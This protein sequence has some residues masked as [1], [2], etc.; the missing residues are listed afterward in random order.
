MRSASVSLAGTALRGQERTREEGGFEEHMTHGLHFSLLPFFP[1]QGTEAYERHPRSPAGG[2]HLCS[3]LQGC[4]GG[5]PVASSDL[6]GFCVEFHMPC[7]CPAPHIARR[8]EGGSHSERQTSRM[9]SMEP[10]CRAGAVQI[11]LSLLSL[12]PCSSLGPLHGSFFSSKLSAQEPPL[13]GS[14]R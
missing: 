9:T 2:G 3:G 14:P 8:L 4:C 6:S 7:S 5:Q 11:L 1:Q 10:H 13:P 12:N